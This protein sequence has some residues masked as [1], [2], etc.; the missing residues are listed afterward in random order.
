MNISVWIAQ[1]DR[2]TFFLCLFLYQVAR[3]FAL[4]LAASFTIISPGVLKDATLS[5]NAVRT[6]S[7]FL[8]EEVQEHI[9]KL[10]SKKGTHIYHGLFR[11]QPFLWLSF[12]KHA[13]KAKASAKTLSFVYCVKSRSIFLH[14]DSDTCLCREYI[15]KYILIY[16]N[17]SLHR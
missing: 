17:S 8:T 10:S 4:S 1:F 5:P 6:A 13:L 9:T 14:T 15:H 3:F 16:C 7:S 11:L 12:P 2:V